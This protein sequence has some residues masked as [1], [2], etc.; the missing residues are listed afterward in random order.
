MKEITWG[1][2]VV[3][4]NLKLPATSPR[5]PTL[6][7]GAMY[8]LGT[9]WETLDGVIVREME[10]VAYPDYINWPWFA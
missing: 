4:E 9:W 6:I 5:G 8:R 3:N 7:V 1:A 10:G 2:F